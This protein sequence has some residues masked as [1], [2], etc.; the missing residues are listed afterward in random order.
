MIYLPLFNPRE[1]HHCR[2]VNY[3]IRMR[4]KQY[5]D[6]TFYKEMTPKI[7]QAKCKCRQ[8]LHDVGYSLEEYQRMF[9]HNFRCEILPDM[10][11]LL[12]NFADTI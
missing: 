5:F 3:D 4:M 6:R 10:K 2:D 9:R 1:L 12:I 11:K 8:T 7:E